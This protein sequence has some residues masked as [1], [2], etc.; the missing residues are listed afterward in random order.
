M[1]GTIRRPHLA[2]KRVEC[3][4]RVL[5]IG[6]DVQ[7]D[8]IRDV[9]RTTAT[10]QESCMGARCL[11]HHGVSAYVTKTFNRSGV[12][13]YNSGLMSFSVL[14]SF[15][16]FYLGFYNSFSCSSSSFLLH[17]ITCSLL[18]VHFV[19][20]ALS[21]SGSST[22]V[23]RSFIPTEQGSILPVYHIFFL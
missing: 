13:I 9:Q 21:T 12:Y 7:R 16:F 3:R 14:K 15:S 2:N 5:L 6:H 18:Y 19:H 17:S 23:S 11:L 10:L 20:C 1:S 4:R 8:V 22:F